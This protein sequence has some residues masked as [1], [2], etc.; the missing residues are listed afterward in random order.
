MKTN[1]FLRTA[2]STLVA[3]CVSC[4]NP[5]SDNFYGKYKFQNQEV[6]TYSRGNENILE[7]IER[8][9]EKNS[10]ERWRFYT[11]NN[12][13]EFHEMEATLSGTH[14]QTISIEGTGKT[15]LGKELYKRGKEK[16]A[17]TREQIKSAKR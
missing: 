2:L 5:K 6:S 11:Q 3:L 8:D 15:K 13:K 17:K 14:N 4:A 7:I 16:Y 10:F 12:S 1:Y 9:E